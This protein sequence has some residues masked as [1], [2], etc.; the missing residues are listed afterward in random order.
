[1]TYCALCIK[2]TKNVMH[3]TAHKGANT[4]L[5]V[6]IDSSGWILYYGI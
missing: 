3:N 4:S 6:R 5:I 2:T 1:M